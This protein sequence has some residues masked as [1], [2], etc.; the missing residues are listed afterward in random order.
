MELLK[1]GSLLIDGLRLTARSIDHRYRNEIQESLSKLSRLAEY[2]R[3][4]HMHNFGK[5]QGAD[6]DPLAIQSPLPTQR[7]S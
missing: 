7:E 6:L 5:V 2:E 3:L 4:S 1:V